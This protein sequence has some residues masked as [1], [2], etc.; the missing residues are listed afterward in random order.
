[1]KSLLVAFLLLASALSVR[2][3][4]LTVGPEPSADYASISDAISAASDGDTIVVAPGVYEERIDFGGLSIT[5]TSRDP[6]DFISVRSTVITTK[7]GYSVSF[8]SGETRDAVLMGFTI[9]GRGIRCTGSS[10]AIAHNVIDECSNSAITGRN[11]ATPLITSNTIT[12]NLDSA[13]V[14]CHGPIT[15]NTML[16]NTA[17]NGAAIYDCDGEIKNNI[18]AGNVASST[19]LS[20]G[21]GGALAFCDGLIA[22]NTFVGNIARNTR[23]PESHGFGGA[24]YECYGTIENN[25]FAGNTANSGGAIYADQTT[26]ACDYSLF[27]NNTP[28]HAAGTVTLS[29]GTLYANPAFATDGAWDD[30]GTPD[31]FADDFW[32]D[33]DY[34][35]KSRQGR[36]K[37]SARQWIVDTAMSPAIDAGKPDADWKAELWPHGKR[38]NIGA[39]ANTPEASM[40]MHSLGDIADFNQDLW[41]DF[42]DLAIL[43]Q[44]WLTPEAPV[45]PD[46]TR[47]GNVDFYD[48]AVFVSRWTPTPVVPVPPKP[49]PMT[50]DVQPRAISPYGIEMTA[51]TAVSTDNSG[52]EYLFQEHYALNIDSGWVSFGP[53]ETPRWELENLT[54]DTYYLF[55]VKARNIDNQLETEWSHSRPARTWEE[56]IYVPLPN[57]AEWLVRPYPTSSG[58]IAM[59]AVEATDPSGVEYRFDCVSHPALSSQWQDSPSYS[60]TG[61]GGGKY[62]FTVQYRDK[63]PA[64]NAGLT[65]LEAAV[66]FLAPTPNPMQWDPENLPHLVQANPNDGLSYYAVMGCVEAEDENEPVQYYFYCDDEP[67]IAPQGF[68]SGWIDDPEWSVKVGR[69]QPYRFR[70]KARDAAGNE[71]EWSS[72][73]IAY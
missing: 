45:A 38:A 69:R 43:S 46:L 36:Y 62:I 56:D 37:P 24:V 27:H 71:T 29:T 22:C 31:D 58:T 28:D 12:N 44:L 3:G 66:D 13:I 2:A 59:T 54:P 7:F 64:R 39:F 30:N 67:K 11:G 41:V 40:S 23:R 10:P 61:L 70:V 8:T 42:V 47:D 4:I 16:S 51:T 21:N 68:S 35:L 33:G 63:S 65:S 48:L 17:D 73:V 6:L 32:V 53:S 15:S 55:R 72:I 57:P 34:H 52:V 1:M 5:L 9:T 25:I 50:W 19:S 49:D 20:N 18:F 14:D 26:V 60:V